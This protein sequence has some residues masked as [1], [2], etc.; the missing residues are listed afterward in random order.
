MSSSGDRRGVALVFVLLVMLA[1][2]ALGHGALASSLGELAASRAVARQ[3]ELRA[4]ADAAV[5]LALR[6]RGGAWMDSVAVGD[7]RSLGTLTLGRTEAASTLRRL[8]AESWLAEGR[9]RLGPRAAAR[10]A[11]LAWALDPLTRIV[12]LE[13]AL[14]VGPNAIVAGLGAVDASDPTRIDPPQ[15]VADCAPWLLDLVTRYATSPLA[16]VSLSVDTAGGPSLG[17]L[18]FD[19]LLAAASDTVSGVGT[20]A[21]VESMG[22]CV[23]GAAWGWGDPGGPGQPCGPHLPLRASLG[24]LTVQGGAGQGMLVVDGDLT[25][26][27][28]ARYY[29]LVVL[30]GALR[31]EGGSSLDGLALARGGADVGA[32]SRL[33]ASACWA[34]RALAAQRQELGGF[35]AVPGVPPIGPM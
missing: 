2:V 11:R 1:L 29:G 15:A 28:S 25:L 8:A 32:G 5:S 35:R 31:L 27:A 22:L 24:D 26:T 9:G 10:S 16:P 30:R 3:L 17:L 20:P 7:A 21:P 13:G 14:T 19:A 4:A 6:E 34:V 23:T 33:V 12:T 18:D